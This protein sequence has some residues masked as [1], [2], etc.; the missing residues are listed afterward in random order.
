MSIISPPPDSET[1]VII[2]GGGPVGCTLSLALSNLGISSVVLERETGIHPLPRAA[3]ID[4]EAHRSLLQQGLGASLD[5]ILTPMRTAEYVDVDGNRLAG[6]DLTSRRVHGGLPPSSVHFQPELEALLRQALAERGGRLVEGANVTSVTDHGDGATVT[7]A[8]GESLSAKWVVACDGASSTVR[9]QLGLSRQDLGFDQDWLVVDIEVNDRE[10][11]GLPDV[12]RQVCDPARP[13][14]MISGHG[15]MYRWEFQLQP[16]EDPIEVNSTENIWSLLSPW[17]A[18]DAAR[19]VRSAAYKFHAGVVT[20]WRKG[21]VMLAGDSAHQMPPFMGQGLNSGMRDAFNLA[22]KLKWVA[23]GWAGDSLL[24]TYGLERIDHVRML[25]E[26]SVEAGLLIDQ[27]AGRV[28]HGIVPRDG[29]GGQR[30]SPRIT[31][32]VVSGEH[33]RIGRLYPWWHETSQAPPTGP[34]MVLVSRNDGG[35]EIPHWSGPWRRVVLDSGR[36]FDSDYVVVRPDGYVAAVCSDDDLPR[37]LD[38][39]RSSMSAT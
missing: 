5:N 36:T 31:D 17:I 38:D 24:D 12:A 21:S 26:T 8:D 34:A 6:E 33:P 39:L 2:V 13:T 15:R 7:C 4:A 10:T 20:E 18:P 16:G 37:I 23:E 3:L 19:L 22:W 11:C 28:S 29:Y 9:R 25:V 1:N 30:P 32:G 27:F 35:T 14:T